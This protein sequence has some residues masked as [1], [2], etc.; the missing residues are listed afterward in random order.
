MGFFCNFH[1]I[2][3]LIVQHKYLKV[4]NYSFLCLT[5]MNIINAHH[6]QLDS[7]NKIP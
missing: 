4:R 3:K 5:D 7:N 6:R 1:Y 2:Y